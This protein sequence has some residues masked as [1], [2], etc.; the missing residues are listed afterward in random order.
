MAGGVDAKAQGQRAGGTR[1]GQD[2]SA[3]L[4]KSK[5]TSALS[6]KPSS[7]AELAPESATD[8]RP[9]V[10]HWIST[11]GPGAGGGWPPAIRPAHRGGR[12][13]RSGLAGWSPIRWG[14]R[15]RR[16]GRGDSRRLADARSRTCWAVCC[17]DGG[18]R[19]AASS[20]PGERA[21]DSLREVAA[22]RGWCCSVRGMWRVLPALYAPAGAWRAFTPTGPL[23][24]DPASRAWRRRRRRPCLA[25]RQQGLA[26]A[27][28]TTGSARGLKKPCS[29]TL[30]EPPPE[31]PRQSAC[32]SKLAGAGPG[33]AA[34]GAPPASCCGCQLAAPGLGPIELLAAAEQVPAAEQPYFLLLPDPPGLARGAP[35]GHAR[36][37]L[38]SPSPTAAMT[39]DRVVLPCSIRC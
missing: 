12:C 15:A 6:G 16:N 29:I 18:R 1:V 38:L 13:A 19:C 22:G 3:S 33:E 7:A 39:P 37:P 4:E 11:A 14:D 8:S 10:C 32:C 26:G 28:T 2:Q 25:C 31:Q 30:Q 35:D 24:S 9:L 34:A 36:M 20:W 27:K 23:R 5:R 17:S 21:A